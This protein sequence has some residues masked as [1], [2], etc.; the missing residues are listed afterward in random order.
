MTQFKPLEKKD[1]DT[2]SSLMADFYAIDHYPFNPEVTQNLFEEFI[3]NKNLGQGWLMLQDNEVAGYLILTFVF[4]FEYQGM[5][6]F[7]DELYVLPKA[8]GKGIGKEA[9]AFAQAH[10]KASGIRLIYLEVENHN[11]PAQQLY[12]KN[13]F[14]NH[15][16]KLMQYK[17]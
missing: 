3:E 16:R 15:P 8:Q 4:S 12:Q 2:I 7:L 14:I 13:G 10:C 17:L 6:A 9:V 11:V 5:I 1:I